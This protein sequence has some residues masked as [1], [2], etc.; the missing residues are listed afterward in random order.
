MNNNLI[1]S[2]KKFFLGE[3]FK[4]NIY[5]IYVLIKLL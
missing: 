5:F 1:N 4:N 3:K 2:I